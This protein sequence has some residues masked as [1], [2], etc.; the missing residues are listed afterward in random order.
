VRWESFNIHKSENEGITTY[1]TEITKGHRNMTIDAIVGHIAAY[2]FFLCNM[3]DTKATYP[4]E[5]AII[6]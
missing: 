6:L 3:T 1:F 4:I 5:C 2:D